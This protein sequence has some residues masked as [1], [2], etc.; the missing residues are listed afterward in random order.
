MKMR[1]LTL[2]EIL[3]VAVLVSAVGVAIFQTFNSGLKLWDRGNRLT[4]E[5]D[6]FIWLDK[7][8]EDLT[9]ALPMSN[10][11]FKGSEMKL[12]FP[13]LVI[14]AA[15]ARSSRAHEELADQIGA[16]EYSFEPTEGK[17]FRRQANYGQALK[18]QWGEA[19]EVAQGIAEARFR[20]YV[21]GQGDTFKSNV[22]G[23]LPAGVA[24]EFRLKDSPA[25]VWL[26]RSFP[27][28]VGG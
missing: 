21:L 9:S 25:D 23:R 17:I 1:G 27:I 5:T 13:A 18:K 19:Q 12:A 2:V 15:D 11:S 3:L 20:Y 4:Y 16:V 22:E 7:M 6:V 10:L 24:V 8:G 28:P 14:A 26:K